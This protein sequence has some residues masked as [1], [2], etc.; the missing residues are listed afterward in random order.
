MGFGLKALGL[1]HPLAWRSMQPKV[2]CSW[3]DTEISFED[4]QIS[5]LKVM[6]DEFGSVSIYQ[7]T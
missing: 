4:P 6:L 5:V 1:S 2:V 7:Q 3:F